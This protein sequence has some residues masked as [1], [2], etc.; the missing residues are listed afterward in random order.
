MSIANEITRLQG[1]KAGLKTAIEGKG[2]TVPS[3]AKLDDYPD[4]VD[5]IPQGGDMSNEA[6]DAILALARNVAYINQDGMTL[7]NALRNA[8]YPVV[9]ISAVYTQSGT[10][11]DTDSL[12][13]LKA[14]L[15]VTAH[16]S[17]SSTETLPASAYTLSGT[18]EEGTS[19]ITVT[20]EDKTDTFEVVVEIGWDYI[21][22]DVDASSLSQNTQY[23]IDNVNLADGDVI[24]ALVT[25]STTES[26]V[27]PAILRIGEGDNSTLL[28]D[29]YKRYKYIA[30]GIGNSLK[31][32]ASIA[33]PN[34][35]TSQQSSYRYVL[36]D[37]TNVTVDGTF[38]SKIDKDGATINGVNIE[39]MTGTVAT[40]TRKARYDETK[41]WFLTQSGF[42]FGLNASA[43]AY[44]N[45]VRVRRT[46]AQTWTLGRGVYVAQSGAL[47][48]SYSATNA[49]ALFARTIDPAS[50]TR[51]VNDSS[52]PYGRYWAIEIPDGATGVDITVPADVYCGI[53]TCYY[54]G[55]KWAA[56]DNDYYYGPSLTKRFTFASNATH[57]VAYIKH[58]SDGTA[59]V[60]QEDIDGVNIEFV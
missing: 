15:V 47:A 39:D 13:D 37:I 16:Y 50:Y 45:Y 12:D 21:V 28:F 34:N 58:G 10:V 9:S 17:D 49:R 35:N 18:L 43:N 57:F 42:Y 6:K 1:A 31:S 53:A 56:I 40:N 41:A 5:S 11:Y 46:K 14:D 48:V 33:N 51:L 52:V 38:E 23:L 54:D 7:Y 4:L 60:T 44:L 3:S 8:F 27:G 20:Y 30:Y 19:T 24:E 26:G 29:Y 36:N 32:V 22:R 59:A 2:V 55:T 25:T